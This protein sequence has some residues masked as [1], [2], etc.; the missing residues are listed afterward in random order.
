MLEF[1]WCIILVCFIM[2]GAIKAET[3]K[4]TVFNKVF[5]IAAT[6]NAVMM[7]GAIIKIVYF[8]G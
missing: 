8:K 6:F 3:D 4:P 5:S 7:I 2:I 1:S